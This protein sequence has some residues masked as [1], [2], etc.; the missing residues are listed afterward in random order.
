MACLGQLTVNKKII[1]LV[2]S[3][4]T[5]STCAMYEMDNW[6]QSSLPGMLNIFFQIISG[7]M[8]ELDYWN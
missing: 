2:L 8:Y 1:L 3:T 6:N 5:F 7:A 4:E